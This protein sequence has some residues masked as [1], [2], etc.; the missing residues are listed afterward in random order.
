MSSMTAPTSTELNLL[1]SDD[2]D[3]DDGE[4]MALGAADGTAAGGEEEVEDERTNCL[5]T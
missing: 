1:S 2:G 5:S 4:V 3:F